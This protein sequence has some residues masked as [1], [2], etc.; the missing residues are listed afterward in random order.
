MYLKKKNR[1]DVDCQINN[2][3]ILRSTAGAL[4]EKDDLQTYGLY[5]I[6]YNVNHL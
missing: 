1:T 6:M 2:F 3:C 4:Y 5:Y